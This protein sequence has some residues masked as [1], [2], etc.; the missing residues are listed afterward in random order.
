[1]AR[2]S[3]T[4]LLAFQSLH[5]LANEPE[6]F[7]GHSSFFSYDEW[8]EIHK[9]F[10]Q[11]RD[12]LVLK[13]GTKLKGTI[14]SLPAIHYAFRPLSFAVEEIGAISLLEKGEGQ[15]IQYIT[16]SGLNYIGP[17]EPRATFLF[18]VDEPNQKNSKHVVQ[19]GISASQISFIIL[20]KRDFFQAEETSSFFTLLL[21]TG[22]Q[23]PVRLP[24]TPIVFSNGWK[25]QLL[26]PFSIIE[27]NSDG[28]V[29][30]SFIQGDSH[31]S[32]GFAFV[33][34]TFLAFQTPKIDA[35]VKMPWSQVAKLQAGQ[36][37]FLSDT[38]RGVKTLTGALFY[39]P[40]PKELKFEEAP[41]A[42]ARSTPPDSIGNMEGKELAEAAG[43]L[44]V[45]F[46]TIQGLDAIGNEPLTKPPTADLSDLQEIME[47]M[48]Y[49]DL[50][51]KE[52]DPPTFQLPPEVSLAPEVEA[53]AHLKL[54]DDEDDFEDLAW[55][56]LPEAIQVHA[57]WEDFL[58]EEDEELFESLASFPEEK[59]E[60][61][62]HAAD[63]ALL[64]D[65]KNGDDEEERALLDA[66]F[67]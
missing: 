57:L 49:E 21:K 19:K 38:P 10:S 14:Q 66:L 12:F 60:E 42:G 23:L 48:L 31:S 45:N 17:I 51:K 6:K 27:L 7:K 22:E 52:I 58:A 63:V 16:T 35:L 65:P 53:C 3:L 18:W 36:N 37:G 50:P 47:V 67:K 11:D 1:M 4:F 39:L 20:K 2:L 25:E 54:A 61:K 28:G 44:G 59:E 32:F 8:Q 40:T 41:V 9:S 34:D 46:K 29:T 43:F 33:K 64:L 13:D 55:Q 15:F 30:G 56:E 24:S 62:P 5:A 26:D